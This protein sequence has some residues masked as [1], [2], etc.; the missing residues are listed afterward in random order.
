MFRLLV[1]PREKASGFSL[2]ELMIVVAIIAILAA[3]AV[4]AYFNHLMRSRQTAVVSELMAI[5]AAQERFFAERGGYA[6]K[7]NTVG[8]EYAPGAIY[9]SGFY[10]YWITANTTGLVTSGAITANA[11]GD[12]NGDGNFT[13]E[14]EVSIDN[15]DEKAKPVLDPVTHEPVSAEGFTWSSMANLFKVK[16]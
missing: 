1:G 7:M 9:T 8:F 16:E 6:P 14:W 12:L 11:K 13:D 5:K 2:V 3:V 15:L 4:P 10:Q